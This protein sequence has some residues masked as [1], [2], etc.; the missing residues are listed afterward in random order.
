MFPLKNTTAN[1]RSMLLQKWQV[2]FF[3]RLST[4]WEYREC[5]LKF[6][7][8]ELREMSFHS[9]RQRTAMCSVLGVGNRGETVLPSPTNSSRRYCRI[10]L[11]VLSL[12]QP[13]CAKKNCLW[14]F[15]LMRGAVMSGSSPAPNCRTAPPA[16]WVSCTPARKNST[17]L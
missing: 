3:G 2:S 15:G 10:S 5:L 16:W 4:G 17:K 6:V 1:K 7:I 12:F 9:P 14:T 13:S 11:E 8:P